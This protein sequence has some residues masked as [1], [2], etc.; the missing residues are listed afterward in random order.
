MLPLLITFAPIPAVFSHIVL[1]RIVIDGSG[2]VCIA[3]N[4][5]RIDASSHQRLVSRIADKVYR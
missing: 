5:R 1:Y 3:A 4:R 2:L